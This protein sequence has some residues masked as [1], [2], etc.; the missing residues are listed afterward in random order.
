MQQV[1]PSGPTKLLTSCDEAELIRSAQHD[2]GA[3][4]ALY[5]LH[6]HRVF[7]YLRSRTRNDDDAA[8][9]TQQVFLQ[10]LDA[11]PRYEPRGAPFVSWLLRIARNC[12]INFQSRRRS[13]ARWD[14]LPPALEPTVEG[15]FTSGC[16]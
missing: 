15:D 6:V 3:F 1:A 2:R 4:G 10:A 14:L 8:D 12:A 11:L 13:T 5:E 16:A 7:A 9:L